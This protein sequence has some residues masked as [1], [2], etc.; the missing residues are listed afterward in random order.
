MMQSKAQDVSSRLRDL[1]R[2]ILLDF[3]ESML[4]DRMTSMGPVC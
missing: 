2:E 4:R 3:E 1:C